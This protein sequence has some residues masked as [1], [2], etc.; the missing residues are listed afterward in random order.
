MSYTKGAKV[1]AYIQNMDTKEMM[2]FQ[3][4]PSTFIYGRSASFNES[5]SPASPYPLVSYS[6]GDLVTFSVVV[7]MFDPSSK[8][9]IEPFIKFLE[10]FLPQP[11][12]S[13]FIER[14]PKPKMMLFCYGRFAR[15]CVMQ[16]VSTEYVRYNEEGL[17][18]QVNITMTLIEIGEISPYATRP[19]IITPPPPDNPDYD[20]PDPIDPEV[21][22][23]K[24]ILVVCQAHVQNMGDQEP[25]TFDP[26]AITYPTTQ[27]TTVTA[28]V[29]LDEIVQVGTEGAG[30]RLE[31]FK[32]SVSSLKYDIGVV[33]QSHCENIGWGEL[34]ENGE[35]TGT[36]GEGLRMEAFKVYLTG[37]DADKYDITYQTH[38]QDT[39]W[40]EWKRNGRFTGTVGIAR[41]LEAI[42]FKITERQPNSYG[43]V[44]V[45]YKAHCQNKGWL[46]YVR[47]NTMTGSTGVGLRME[48]LRFYLIDTDGYDL[49]L[50][51]KAHVQ[52][53][54]WMDKVDECP[55]SVPDESCTYIGTV[56]QGLRM[57]SVMIF[58][59]GSDAHRFNV[60]YCIHAENL[61]WLAYSRNGDPSGTAGL[62][63]RA[64]AIKIYIDP[65]VI[66]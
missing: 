17:P 51:A 32:L 8:G 7:P 18:I 59:E 42:R 53:L 13:A 3:F 64:E 43:E 62:G 14:D 50:T 58:L 49:K 20:D 40:G 44:S 63:N 33:Y 35:W 54:G 55:P 60:N 15:K 21:P 29:N 28:K 65:V 39:S 46:P 25:V 66:K 12:T 9:L 2:K 41:R 5:S 57:E 4:N 24:D 16:N 56:G 22:A 52:N 38:L 30:L 23:S 48:A 11:D 34:C 1:K 19:P 61:N 6:K 10:T 27:P 47:D 37:K 36:K 26:S 45:G 31:A